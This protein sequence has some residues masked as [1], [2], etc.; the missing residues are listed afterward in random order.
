[1][2]VIHAAAL[3]SSYAV[4]HSLKIVAHTVGDAGGTTQFWNQ[5]DCVVSAAAQILLFCLRHDQRLI[6]ITNMDV[7]ALRKQQQKQIQKPIFIFF[8]SF[9]HLIICYSTHHTI[10]L[11]IRHLASFRVKHIGRLYFEIDVIDAIRAIVVVG[12]HDGAEHFFQK[13]TAKIA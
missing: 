13:I 2:I 10:I 12:E 1:M 7:V 9:F 4:R 5:H 8:L 3:I 6:M 11:D